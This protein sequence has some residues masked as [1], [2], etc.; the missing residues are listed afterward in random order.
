MYNCNISNIFDLP[1][2][3]SMNRRKFGK[4]K[5]RKIERL[6]KPRRADPQVLTVR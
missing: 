6:S 1:F 5:N 2:K 3:F 4:K